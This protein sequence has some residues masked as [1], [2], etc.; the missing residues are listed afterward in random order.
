MQSWGTQSRFTV[1]DTGAEP[2]KSGA[3]GLICAALG[4]PRDQAVDDLASLKM[5]VRVDRE[6]VMAMDFHTAG[7]SHRVGE[8][9]GVISADGKH[10]RTVT[11]NRY[12]LADADFLVGFEGDDWELL[13]RVQEA[14]GNPRWA[15]YLG[16]KAFTPSVPVFIPDGLRRDQAL[17]EALKTYPWPRLMAQLPTRRPERLRAVLETAIGVGE[18]VRCDQPVGAAF[19]YPRKFTLRHITTTFWGLG[20]DVPIREDAQ[21]CSSHD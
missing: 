17:V 15:L 13:E 3:I 7:G 1:R 10:I 19:E 12:Y 16:R 21:A 2:S 6:G 8:V 11:S 5:G 4:R 18:E 20:D 9:Y 14:L